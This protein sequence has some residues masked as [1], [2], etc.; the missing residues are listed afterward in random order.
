[1]F[2]NS[3]LVSCEGTVGIG[4]TTALAAWALRKAIA[5]GARRIFIVAPFTAILSQ[6]AMRLRTAVV[7]P[8]EDEHRALS[9]HHHR[10]EFSSREG[11]DLAVLW[12][13]PIVL[14]TAVQFFETLAS[15]HPGALRKLHALP[16]S[17]IVIDEAHAAL[18]APLLQQ[19]WRWMRELGRYWRCTFLFASGSLARYWE[20]EEIVGED[21]VDVLPEIVPPN[22][23]SRARDGEKRRVRY[24][25]LGRLS[26]SDGIAAAIEEHAGK[27]GGSLLVMNTVQNAAVMAR[28]LAQRGHDVLHLST[29][30]CPR[31]RTLILDLVEKRLKKNV[32]SPWFLVATSLVEAGVDLSFQTAFRERFSV[33]SLIQIGGRV[34]R[35]GGAACGIVYD[36]FCDP[37]DLLV[38]NP[39]AKAP[40]KVVEDFWKE[41]RF[42]NTV[43][44]AGLTTLALRKEL[45]DFRGTDKLSEAETDLSYP[46]VAK[47][48][49]IINCDTRLVVV[50]PLMRDL[51][52]AR[53]KVGF[54]KL[55]E[56]S[57]QIQG[58]KLRE[59]CLTEP[60]ISDE[61]VYWWPHKYE[62]KGLGYMAGVLDLNAI[63]NGA[64]LI[65]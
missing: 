20:D 54:R 36:F 64:M 3:P 22:L 39:A 59:L 8:G 48:G 61:E 58:W 65:V 57:V 32:G 30:L 63:E 33:S 12:S 5:T 9:E 6:T 52:S 25:S 41:R 34:N 35:H 16:G 31:D 23:A 24:K 44:P 60:L 51:L 11:R 2:E 29:A 45:A 43:D 19:N 10:A 7:L 4:K 21:G 50:D 53:R 42:E 55:L 46:D 28:K 15:N 40:A 17:V 14:T 26:G 13:T 56:G 18:P 38:A 37:A 1:L 47:L 27:H 62:P 49:R